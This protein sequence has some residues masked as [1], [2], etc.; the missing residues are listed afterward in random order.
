MERC[1]K[2]GN[3][4]SN[5]DVLCPRCG[6]LVEV[7]QVKNSF[8]PPPVTSESTP[9]VCERPNLVIYNEDFPGDEPVSDE[10]VTDEPV[11]DEESIL[12][13]M[14]KEPES[15]DLVQP[16]D[17]PLLQPS[18]AQPVQPF[19]PERLYET[20]QDLEREIQAESR[21]ARRARQ[22]K[23]PEPQDT[24]PSPHVSE[25]S[26]NRMSRRADRHA[27]PSTPEEQLLDEA[28]QLTSRASWRSR[29]AGT[30]ADAETSEIPEETLSPE[31][32]IEKLQAS[33]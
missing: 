33:L 9:P 23:W 21:M 13:I 8:V 31:E 29:V 11:S 10:P 19:L 26:E 16:E 7:I 27:A 3:K 28:E 14:E 25:E 18:A 4:L 32:I 6:A 24:Q 2:C 12:D 30:P 22:K 1:P 20:P 5:V 17:T 15:S